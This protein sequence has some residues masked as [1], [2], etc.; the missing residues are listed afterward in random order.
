MA[1]NGAVFAWHHNLDDLARFRP[2]E[3]ICRPV[4]WERCCCERFLGRRVSANQ[5]GFLSGAAAIH[6]QAHLIA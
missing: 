1:V 4:A 2:A 5:E 3:P 6:S